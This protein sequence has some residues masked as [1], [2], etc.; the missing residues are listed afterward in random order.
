MALALE[1]Y[2]DHMQFLANMYF[3]MGGLIFGGILIWPCCSAP[4]PEEGEG[5][6][7]IEVTGIDGMDRATSISSFSTDR[8]LDEEESSHPAVH[9]GDDAHGDIEGR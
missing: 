9:D 5:R 8:D 7:E 1:F 2:T 3:G 4:V 6:L